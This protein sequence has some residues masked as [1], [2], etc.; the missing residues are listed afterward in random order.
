MSASI[1][2]VGSKED[3]RGCLVTRNNFF[4]LY[5]S[6]MDQ[7]VIRWVR[8]SLLETT[9][10]CTST[11]ESGLKI[12]GKEERVLTWKGVSAEDDPFSSD[13]ETSLPTFGDSVVLHGTKR[14]YG[15]EIVI[16]GSST[17]DEGEPRFL[18]FEKGKV[19]S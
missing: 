3:G 11:E 4:G 13:G 5:I 17:T 15:N 18:G 8:T 9:G 1:T 2:L 16:D 14:S 7:V 6:F 19:P 12:K 10:T